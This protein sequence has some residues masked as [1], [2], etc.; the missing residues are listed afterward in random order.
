MLQSL[1]VSDQQ[2]SYVTTAAAAFSMLL[3][4]AAGALFTT[5]IKPL[6]YWPLFLCSLG[7]VLLGMQSS[8]PLSIALYIVTNALNTV[9]FAS[10]SIWTSRIVLRGQ[11]GFAF[12]FH[13]IFI[14][15]FGFA[16][17]VILSLM[18]VKLGI[19][20]CMILMGLLGIVF[21]LLLR[22]QMAVQTQ[23]VES[24]ITS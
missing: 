7:N 13:K 9:S 8:L 23:P 15:A 21:T 19:D 1:G 17:S 16:F 5:K 2:F 12:A 11:I 14:A 3:V 22:I 6:V 24:E 18:E 20:Y 4:I 10:V